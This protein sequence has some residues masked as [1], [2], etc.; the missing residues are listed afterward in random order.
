MRERLLLGLLSLLG[1]PLGPTW[2]ASSQ[3]LLLTSAPPPQDTL[4]HHL[5]G[6]GAWAARHLPFAALCA[7]GADAQL[8]LDRSL[9]SA[10]TA[11]ATSSAAT[12]SAAAAATL[13][14]APPASGNAP[15]PLAPLLPGGHGGA[16][17]GLLGFA[18]MVLAPAACPLPWYAAHESRRAML[19]RVLRVLLGRGAPLE[20]HPG[21]SLAWLL[22]EA[23]EPVTPEAAAAG[24]AAGGEGP[25][26]AGARAW[27]HGARAREAARG[28]LERQRGNLA[29][30][31]AL[32]AFESLMGEVKVSPR[33]GFGTR[34]QACGADVASRARVVGALP[35]LLAPARLALPLSDPSPWR[36]DDTG[37][38]DWRARDMMGR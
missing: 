17:E 20:G 14:L 35:V 31:G 7:T 6:P 38:R 2:A 33:E 28:L 27:V 16:G 19:S 5:L 21:V 13:G 8:L 3:P 24:G 25:A 9:P 30:W 26:W 32:A 18:G 12:T 15:L 22:V 1:A 34:V 10:T 37:A 11:A 23:T 29:M 4:S 36:A